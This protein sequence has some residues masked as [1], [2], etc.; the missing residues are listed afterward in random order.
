ML[1]RN[2]EGS[3]YCDDDDIPQ[4]P[5]VSCVEE[6]ASVSKFAKLVTCKCCDP[7]VK[8]DLDSSDLPRV[9]FHKYSVVQCQENRKKR[10]F[11]D[12]LVFGN[13]QSAVWIRPSV[14]RISLYLSTGKGTREGLR[15]GE[16][17][18]PVLSNL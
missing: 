13:A 18:F 14:C 2:K 10:C 12:L 9:A 5:E 4:T 8:H 7:H 6:S 11:K 17:R 3:A 1:T 16:N 15:F